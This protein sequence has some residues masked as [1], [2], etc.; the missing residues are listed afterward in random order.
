MTRKEHIAWLKAIKDSISGGDE[1]FDNKRRESLDAGIS[2][3]EQEPC[4][5]IN[6]CDMRANNVGV[7][8]SVTPSRHKGH[9]KRVSID[10]Y[11]EHAHYWYECDKCGKQHLGNTNYCPNCGAEMVKPQESEDKE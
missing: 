6:G 9:W 5:V 4:I 3:L 8:P 11:S 2:A 10:K 1:E 7:M